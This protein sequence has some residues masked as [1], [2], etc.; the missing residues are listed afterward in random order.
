MPACRHLSSSYRQIYH[1]C[2]FPARSQSV[3]LDQSSTWDGGSHWKSKQVDGKSQRVSPL[4]E[5]TRSHPSTLCSF[6]GDFELT[7]LGLGGSSRA[8]EPNPARPRAWRLIPGLSA[9]PQ[10][11]ARDADHNSLQVLSRDGHVSASPGEGGKKC[12][13]RGPW[14]LASGACHSH[15]P[16]STTQNP[17]WQG[18]SEISQPSL[19]VYSRKGRRAVVTVQGHGAREG[20]GGRSGKSEDT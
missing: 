7:R 11:R 8:R 12:L 18:T 4:L 6:Q 3:F 16:S 20:S 9:F 1:F 17:S 10:H 14:Q 15:T 19:S 2:W 13:P 5:G